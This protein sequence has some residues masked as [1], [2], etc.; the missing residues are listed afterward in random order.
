MS[1]SG[2]YIDSVQIII[3]SAESYTDGAT[4]G[5]YDRQSIAVHELGHAIGIYDISS[6]RERY[7]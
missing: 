6:K 1:Q 7:Q 5:R 3:D 4:S 2:G